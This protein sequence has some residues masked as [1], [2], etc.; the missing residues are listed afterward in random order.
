MSDHG[1]KL[2][3]AGI[4]LVFLCVFSAPQY[5]QAYGRPFGG[6]ITQM[7]APEIESLEDAG[8]DCEVPG[9]D[10]LI[11]P[12]GNSPTSYVI[13]YG[14]KSKTSS[15][16]RENVQ[17]LGLYTPSSTEVTCIYDSYPPIE[18]TLEMNTITMYGVSK[19]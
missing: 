9:D 16:A 6:K 15:S 12:K 3:A 10:L 17:I 7:S 8:F 19:Q 2:L 4:C 1:S 18:V 13:P 11:Q 14:T 5:S